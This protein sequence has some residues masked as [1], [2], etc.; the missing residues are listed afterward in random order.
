MITPEQYM[1]QFDIEKLERIVDEKIKKSKTQSILVILPNT[2]E[3]LIK[4]LA[5]RYRIHGW[6]VDY[7]L[8]FASKSNGYNAECH[9]LLRI[10]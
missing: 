5:E 9:F 1:K 6:T 3:F 7:R 8:V 4:K 2:S 10:P